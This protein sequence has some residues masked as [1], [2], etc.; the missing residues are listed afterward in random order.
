MKIFESGLLDYHSKF[1]N[2]PCTKGVKQLQGILY[3]T[4]SN[5]IYLFEEL[6]YFFKLN[7]PLYIYYQ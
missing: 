2:T 3:V 7:S 1:F 5:W 4:K 6:E